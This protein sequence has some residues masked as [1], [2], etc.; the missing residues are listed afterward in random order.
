MIFDLPLDDGKYVI[1]HEENKTIVTRY[2][3]PWRDLTGDNLFYFLMMHGADIECAIG[4]KN[5]EIQSLKTELETLRRNI[6][7]YAREE[8][9][10]IT[11]DG[12]SET[13]DQDV[14]DYFQSYYDGVTG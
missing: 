10:G 2:G 13:P 9:H 3:E 7:V 1:H 6:C 4:E 14:I 11:P 12:D 5:A 8:M